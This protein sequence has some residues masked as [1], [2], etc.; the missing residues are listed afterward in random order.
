MSE[1]DLA[2]MTDE[3]RNDLI[4]ASVRHEKVSPWRDDEDAIA[5][6]R[7]ADIAEGKRLERD[8]IRERL[9]ELSDIAADDGEPEASAA[10]H[11][12]AIE[13]PE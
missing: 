1:R 7:A 6:F 9:L 13:L 5:A 11:G 4:W 10:L 8:R 3:E 12:A 2:K